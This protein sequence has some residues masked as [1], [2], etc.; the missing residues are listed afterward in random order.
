[1]ESTSAVKFKP[2]DGTHLPDFGLNQDEAIVR[3]QISRNIRCQWPQLQVYPPNEHELAIVCGGPSLR[4]TFDDLRARV[5]D[6]VLVCATNNSAKWLLERGITPNIHMMVDSREFMTRF[7]DPPILSCTYVLASQCH[8]SLFNALSGHPRAYICHVGGLASKTDAPA[9]YNGRYVML[10]SGCTVGL[11][12][13]WAMHLL[14]YRA[15]HV[16]GMDGCFAGDEH[17]AYKQPENDFNAGTEKMTGVYEW[18][19]L[20]RTWRGNV[21]M[22][23]QAEDLI[24]T[25]MFGGSADLNIEF[26]GDGFIQHIVKTYRPSKH[27]QLQI[28]EI[29]RIV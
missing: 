19:A 5:A 29:K 10:N 8:P 7:V 14:G 2:E 25:T 16:Y 26:Y 3:D 4:D 17:H 15:L 21:W 1:M 9:Y 6:G 13:I 28:R 18:D 22:M 24:L 12:S 11:A 20:G 23:K 27:G